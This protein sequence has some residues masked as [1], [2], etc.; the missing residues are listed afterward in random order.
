MCVTLFNGNISKSQFVL[1]QNILKY[2]FYFGEKTNGNIAS[3]QSR[4]VE[5]ECVWT[6]GTSNPEAASLY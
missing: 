4:F 2:R 5:L 3:T 6:H 1:W